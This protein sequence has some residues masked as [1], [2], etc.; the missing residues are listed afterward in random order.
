MELFNWLGELQ[1]SFDLAFVELGVSP[2]L[3]VVVF[4]FCCIDAVFPIVPSDSFIT[5]AT[6]LALAAEAPAGFL[7]ML[8]AAGA[9]GGFSGDCLAYTLG[10]K[11]P[12]HRMPGLRGRR[13]QAAFS[14]TQR[15]FAKR[16]STLL[17]TG[18]FIP[19]G[20]IV[21]NMTA[22]ATGFRLHRFLP[23]AAFAGVLWASLAALVGLLAS[24]FLPDST[25]FAMAVGI[26]LG[27]LFG[28]V[29]DWVLQ[30]SSR[31]AQNNSSEL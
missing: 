19:V 31:R 27:I 21:V 4:V 28:L 23:V 25:L 2:W 26:C 13:G 8:V 16:G 22:G 5:A 29:L 9:L 7:V 30:R 18:R 3:I 6:V 11:V 12:V 15:V 17:L 20:R 14:T 1:R 24:H 10:S